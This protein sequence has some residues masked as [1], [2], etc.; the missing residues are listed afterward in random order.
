MTTKK[1]NLDEFRERARQFR[2]E[3]LE[4][5][6]EAGSGHP[7]GSL[8]GVEILISLYYYKMRHKPEN[9]AWPLRDRFIMSK[10]HA[11]PLLYVVLANCGYFPKEEL[12][13]FRKLGSRLQGHVYAGVPGVEL[14]TGSLGQGFSVGNG[15]AL[16]A[17]IRGVNFRVYTLL[18]DG[19]IQEGQVWEAAMTAGHHKLDNVCA[20]LDRNGVQE[21]G[22][23]EEIKKEE[24]LADKWKS[25][26]WHVLDVNGHDFE[27]LIDALDQAETVKGKPIFIIA[28]TVKGKGVSFMEGQAKWHGKAPDKEQLAK[29][30]S[31]LGF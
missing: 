13:T 5:I 8:S 22:P 30:L 4:T 15:I 14:S 12:K 25:F 6:T 27:Q 9:P 11:S 10:G 16:G 20:I 7:G 19:E 21:N 17:K 1:I 31:E 2:K 3:I 29:A 18:G 28:R 26:G 23:V 24:P